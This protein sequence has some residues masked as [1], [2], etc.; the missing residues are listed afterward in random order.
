[1][2]WGQ[3]LPLT[4]SPF[5]SFTAELETREVPSNET[6]FKQAFF[7]SQFQPAASAMM[8]RVLDGRKQDQ[9]KDTSYWHSCPPSLSV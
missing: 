4:W 8:A 6:V 9:F 1:M 3:M 2:H 5:Y 7:F